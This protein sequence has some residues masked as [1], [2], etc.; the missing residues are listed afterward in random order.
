M[1]SVYMASELHGEFWSLC[2]QVELADW[3]ADT[4]PGNMHV[5]ALTFEVLVDVYNMLPEAS[6]NV[7]GLRVSLPTFYR[8][9]VLRVQGRCIYIY[10][11]YIW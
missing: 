9:N 2:S 1:T 10:I 3:N 5:E 6:G 7:L 8:T 11:T 4:C